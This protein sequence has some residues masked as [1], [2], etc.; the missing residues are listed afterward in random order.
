MRC[1]IKLAIVFSCTVVLSACAGGASQGAYTIHPI[2]NGHVLLVPNLIGGTA[3]W[4]MAIGWHDATEGS[5]ACAAPPVSTGPIIAQ[6]C[7]SDQ[8]K[9]NVY[10][11]TTSDVAAVSL[12]GSASLVRTVD[13]RTLP[14]GVRAVSVEVVRHE[15]RPN[16]C[17]KVVAFGPGKNLIRAGG[18]RSA[19]LVFTLPGRQHW[20]R[21]SEARP[22]GL[23]RLAADDLPRRII[24][25]SGNVATRVVP[26][27]G[28]LGKA[29]LSCADIV[30]IYKGDHRLTSAVLL[31][32]SHP[33]TTPPDLRGM[34]PVPG[35]RGIFESP[36]V[37]GERV[38]RRIPGAWLVVEEEDDIGLRVPIEILQHMSATIRVPSRRGGMT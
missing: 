26:Y 17:P 9:Y 32:A 13:N 3:G 16:A 38:A 14:H 37:E 24:P 33:G 11:L 2:P 21:P 1:S 23:C 31:N 5:G 15:G 12:S 29:L 6:T 8:A 7:E 10:A 25:D 20:A 34:M 35:Q 27:R 18:K 22:K 30:Y 19:P 28:S 4:C 36:G